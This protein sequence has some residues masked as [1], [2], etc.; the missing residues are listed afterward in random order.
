MPGERIV[1]HVDMD[2]FYAGVEEKDR[3]ELRRVPVVVGADPQGGRGRGVV[4][5]A[6]YPARAYGIRSAMPISTAYRLCP[7][8]VFLRPRFRR[9]VEESRAVMA[10]LARYADRLEIMGLDEAYLDAAAAAG[11]DWDRA[12]DLARSLQ[13]AI[14]RE[15]GL[16]ASLGVASNKSLAKIACNQVKP[17]GIT[18]VLPH[19]VQA[20][21]D[22]LPAK[23]LPGCG[24]KTASRLQEMDIR[25][26]EELRTADAAALRR[27]FGSHTDWLLALAEGRDGRP[28]ESDGGPAKSHSNETTFLRDERDLGRV[29][30]VAAGLLAELIGD[31]ERP[32]ST[33]TVKLR[34]ADY[35]TLTRA[36]SLPVPLDAGDELAGEIAGSVVERLLGPLLDGR[37]VRLVGVRLSGFSDGPGQRTLAAFGAGTDPPKTALRSVALRPLH[38]MGAFNPGGLRQIFLEEPAATA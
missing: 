35:T 32:F 38:P 18:R 34:Y 19:D 22:P 33:V 5:T 30:R 2:A 10:I 13:A 1:F 14:R 16:S 17:H 25:T 27:E 31:A 4:C 12:M 26:V 29:R 36:H 24:P 37:A 11:G 23:V 15:T 8:A 6:N 28:V 9:Y 20:F 21:L 7:T 3:P